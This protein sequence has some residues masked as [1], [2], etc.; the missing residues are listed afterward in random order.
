[1]TVRSI[2]CLPAAVGAYG[3]QGGGCLTSVSTIGLFAMDEVLRPDLMAKPTRIVNM[4]RLGWALDAL[5]TP[6]VRSLYVYS[7]N[8]PWWRRTRTRFSGGSG[9]TTSSRWSTSDF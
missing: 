8:P 3:K 5:D 2:A 4:N 1:M 7:S 6:R 9:G